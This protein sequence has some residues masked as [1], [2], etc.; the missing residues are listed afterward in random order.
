MVASQISLAPSN[1]EISAD[2][3]EAEIFLHNGA[4]LRRSTSSH[5]HD[6]LK[7]VEKVAE[8]RPYRQE[9]LLPIEKLPRILPLAKERR[10]PTSV[11]HWD[12]VA[13]IFTLTR[14]KLGYLRR[15]FKFEPL[16]NSSD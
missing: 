6:L 3:I 15:S 11:A 16:R 7:S 12:V 10:L 9:S 8:P 5:R 2:R 13:P 14:P 1:G 4:V